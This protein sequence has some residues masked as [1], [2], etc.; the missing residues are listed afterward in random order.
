MIIKI[1]KETPSYACLVFLKKKL[2]Y[3]IY[4]NLHI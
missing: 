1:I 3:L 4:K 2:T